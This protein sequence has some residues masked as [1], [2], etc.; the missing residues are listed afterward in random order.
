MSSNREIFLDGL[1]LN[2][3]GPMALFGVCPLLAVTSSL[4]T[5]LALGLAT[6]IALVFSNFTVSVVRGRLRPEIRIPAYAL[7]IA[8]VVTVIQLLMQTWFFDLYQVLGI[9]VPLIVTNCAIMGRAETFAVRNSPLPSMLDGFATG[10]GFCLVLVLLGTT[11]ELLGK[12]TLF[13]HGELIFGA[14]GNAWQLAVLPDHYGFSL[15]L[16][17]PGAFMCL[18]FLMAGR[19]WLDSCRA[20][21]ERPGQ[22]VRLRQ[23]VPLE[24]S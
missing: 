13:S 17:P 5:G 24:S 1:R 6:T 4:I 3:T 19:N 20:G 14:P 7:I 23:H 10:L 21:G 8:A 22:A 9:F 15:A 11:R 12:G 2:N 18:G 16:L